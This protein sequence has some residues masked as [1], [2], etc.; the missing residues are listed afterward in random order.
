MT[1]GIYLRKHDMLTYHCEFIGSQVRVE[2]KWTGEVRYMSLEAFMRG[3][4]NVDG[5]R[6]L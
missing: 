6:I 2:D 4:T 1:N 3:Y 5:S